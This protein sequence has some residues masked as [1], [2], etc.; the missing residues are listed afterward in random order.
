MNVN[1]NVV[2]SKVR[3]FSYPGTVIHILFKSKGNNK[4]KS[5]SKRVVQVVFCQLFQEICIKSRTFSPH[6]NLLTEME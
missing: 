1:D 2:S 4:S 6:V 3:Y 5:L